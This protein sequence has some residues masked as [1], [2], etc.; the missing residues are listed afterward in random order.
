MGV[1]LL[2]LS[3]AKETLK[4]I[5][6]HDR[7]YVESRNSNLTARAQ[8]LLGT[9]SFLKVYTSRR[10]ASQRGKNRSPNEDCLLERERARTRPEKESHSK[11]LMEE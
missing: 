11:N 4:W 7:L 10:K 3:S 8:G 1:R 2:D 6:E 5:N 9:S